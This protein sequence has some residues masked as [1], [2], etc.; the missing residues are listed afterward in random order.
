MRR[1][2]DHKPA[3][4]SAAARL[5]SQKRYHEVLMED[6][7][8]AAQVGKGTIYRFYPTKEALL[9]ALCLGSFD[10]LTAELERQAD[11]PQRAS[12]RLARMIEGVVRHFRQRSDVLEI[13]QREWSQACLMKMPA[14]AARRK[15]T[16]SLFARVIREGQAADEFRA[17]DAEVAADM[18]MGM[19][20]NLIRFGDPRLSPARAARM[21]IDVFLQ[22]ISV[23]K[24]KNHR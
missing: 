16:R 12:A 8:A 20:R 24:G 17:L 9:A 15:K 6:V 7:A 11:A 10:E 3:I 4:L 23:R 14:F 21:I 22:G 13:I 18:L 1:P 2:K 19:N 5:F